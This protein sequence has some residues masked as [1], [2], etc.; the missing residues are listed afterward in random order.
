[1]L[2]CWRFNAPVFTFPKGD[3]LKLPGTH[4]SE[5]NG[6]GGSSHGSRQTGSLQD[7][8]KESL[9]AVIQKQ[10][11]PRLL[12]VQQFFPFKSGRSLWTLWRAS[13]LN[14]WNSHNI[15]CAAMPFRPTALWM[16]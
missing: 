11:I 13:S 6:P 14:F 8:C 16:P 10:I 5:F 7:E 12:N 15:A 9:L 3:T 1:M 2:C 4:M